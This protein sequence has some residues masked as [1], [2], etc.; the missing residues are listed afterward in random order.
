MPAK[1]CTYSVS[2]DYLDLLT[3]PP[4]ASIKVFYRPRGNPDVLSRNS[5]PCLVQ[6]Y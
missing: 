4:Y 2:V 6:S 5:Y 1:E 3:G